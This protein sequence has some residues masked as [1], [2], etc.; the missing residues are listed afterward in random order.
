MRF[1]IFLK[2]YWMPDKQIVYFIAFSTLIILLLIG[3]V[4]RAIFLAQQQRINSELLLAE[5]R[6][7]YESELRTIE[8]E[9]QE[10]ALT[11]IG[12]ELHD[13]I[14]QLLAVMNVQLEKEKLQEPSLVAK[15]TPVSNT[16]QSTMEQVRLL[17]HSLSNDF[18]TERGLQQSIAQEVERLQA[19][20]KYNIQF[21]TDEVEPPLSKDA[22]TVAFRI[23]QE[24]IS[25]ALRHA[26]P[27]NIYIKLQGEGDFCL[28][29][30]DDGKG[31]DKDAAMLAS[32]G[33]GLKNMV[34]RA[35]L[36][37]LTCDI[38]SVPDEGATFTVS[39]AVV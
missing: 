28:Q 8:S 1:I 30:R 14:G 34:R 22:R 31:F 12:A 18:I 33:L 24:S 38:E 36:A 6:I 9:V 27:K 4:L 35:A 10:A 5:A 11:Q 21:K 13:N 37:G 3:G 39:Q 16:L 19:I 15:L 20:G 26:K 25:N 2:A 32:K 29:V 17:S 23:F 7:E